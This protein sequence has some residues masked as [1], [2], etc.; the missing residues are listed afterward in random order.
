MWPA[1]SSTGKHHFF[2]SLK[3]P[4]SKELL[5]TFMRHSLWILLI[6]FGCVEQL[7]Q[8]A[9]L[10]GFTEDR[11]KHFVGGSRTSYLS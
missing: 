1:A 11:H 10:Q 3:I 6:L 2:D 5:D 4:N 7:G 9:Y 8:R